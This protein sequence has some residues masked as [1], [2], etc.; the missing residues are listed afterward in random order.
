VDVLG[1]NEGSALRPKCKL[2]KAG[3]PH[4]AEGAG[5]FMD[6]LSRRRQERF[7]PVEIKII[8]TD[9]RVNLKEGQHVI[10]VMFDLNPDKHDPEPWA[11]MTRLAPVDFIGTPDSVAVQVYSMPAIIHGAIHCHTGLSGYQ[12]GILMFHVV[13]VDGVFQGDDGPSNAMIAETQRQ[14]A[15]ALQQVSDWPLI[16]RRKERVG[17]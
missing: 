17:N 3:D 5:E 12:R 10:T 7:T 8:H 11:K 6:K 15:E 2:A 1:L 13:A 4:A 14:L 16:E 9:Q